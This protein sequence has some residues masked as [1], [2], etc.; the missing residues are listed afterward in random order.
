MV[1]SA[2]AGS[3]IAWRTQPSDNATVCVGGEMLRIESSSRGW[4]W[5]SAGFIT[6]LVGF[7]AAAFT[8]GDIGWVTRVLAVLLI[9]GQLPLAVGR[10]AYTELTDE[11]L[12]LNVRVRRRRIPWQ[13]VERI[14]LGGPGGRPA[15]VVLR[16]GSELKSV[17]LGGFVAGPDAEPAPVDRLRT[18]AETHGFAL[19]VP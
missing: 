8:V 18:A 12:V 2:T 1:L 14:E 17:A 16:A 11:G 3:G 19:T 9:V 13:R 5:F 10:F 4:R 15:R 7:A 6:F